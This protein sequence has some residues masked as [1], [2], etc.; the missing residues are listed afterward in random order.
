MAAG[1]RETGAPWA[2]I[3][4]ICHIVDGDE[5]TQPSDF[6]ARESSVG[7][8][9]NSAAMFGWALLYEGLLAATRRKSNAYFATGAAVAAYAIDYKVVPPRYSPGIEKKISRG[10]ILGVYAVLAA[11]LALSPLWNDYDDP[12]ST[13]PPIAG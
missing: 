10:S 11:T 6:S 4:A 2:P 9:V 1:H 7:L 3:N 12:R 8:A 5:V 13:E